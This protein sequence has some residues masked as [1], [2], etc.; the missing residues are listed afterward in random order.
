M[1]GKLAL[2]IA[3]RST[4]PAWNADSFF[5]RFDKAPKATAPTTS[6]PF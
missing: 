2:R 3:N 6:N 4:R 5:R 1:I